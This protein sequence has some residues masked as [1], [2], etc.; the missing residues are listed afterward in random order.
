[1]ANMNPFFPNEYFCHKPAKKLTNH[2]HVSAGA[3]TSSKDQPVVKHP[4]CD[5]V[6]QLWHD[7]LQLLEVLYGHKACYTGSPQLRTT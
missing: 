5:D 7:T 2:G 3:A 1:M 4:K 6:R